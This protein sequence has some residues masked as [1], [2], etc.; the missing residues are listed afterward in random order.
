VP[1]ICL[2][3]PL[4]CGEKTAII[5][6]QFNSMETNFNQQTMYVNSVFDKNVVNFGFFGSFFAVFCHFF[7]SIHNCPWKTAWGRAV[8][9][10]KDPGKKIIFLKAFPRNFCRILWE[11]WCRLQHSNRE[12]SQTKNQKKVLV[13]ALWCFFLMFIYVNNPCTFQ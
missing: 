3:W 1:Q 2:L 7:P 9:L 6:I 8:W 12:T 10:D 4:I 5:P 11:F 13:V